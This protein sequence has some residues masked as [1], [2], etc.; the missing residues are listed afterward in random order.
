MS[1]SVLL[2]VCPLVELLGCTRLRGA[3][4]P[5]MRGLFG[6]RFARLGGTCSS[7]CDPSTPKHILLG[8]RPVLALLVRFSRCG[9]LTLLF[10]LI[11]LKIVSTLT[12]K[13]PF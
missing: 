12:C 1:K 8:A 3:C 9:R 11:V 10:Y 7:V 2:G 4:V 13:G 6:M 5:G